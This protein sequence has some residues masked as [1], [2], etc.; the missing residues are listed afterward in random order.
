MTLEF[1]PKY[2]TDK[3]GKLKSVAHGQARVR[4]RVR[5]KKRGPKDDSAP[6]VGQVVEIQGTTTDG[7][8]LCVGEGGVSA[9]VHVDDLEEV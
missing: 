3:D 5:A 7:R 2:K 8:R 9:W 1:E 4:D 6:L